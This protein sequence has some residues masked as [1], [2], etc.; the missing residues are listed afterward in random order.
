MTTYCNLHVTLN[1][2]QRLFLSCTAKFSDNT[3]CRVPVF[4]ISHDLPLCT[5]HGWK[6]VSVFIY[7]LFHYNLYLN[8]SL[9]YF[10]CLYTKG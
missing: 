5:E 1:S 3:Q 6:R 7:F 2:D 10:I 8:L 9:L 4:D